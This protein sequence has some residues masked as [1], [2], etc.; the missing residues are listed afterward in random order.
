MFV[1]LEAEKGSF[2]NTHSHC[3]YSFYVALV[4]IPV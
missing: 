3:D 2:Y 1:L 4:I